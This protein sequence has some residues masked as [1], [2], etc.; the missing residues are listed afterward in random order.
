ML[1][2]IV[3]LSNRTNVIMVNCIIAEIDQIKDWENERD[4]AGAG[5][6]GIFPRTNAPLGGGKL[7]ARQQRWM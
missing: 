7:A 4:L 3:E 5:N 2:D 6:S 1:L